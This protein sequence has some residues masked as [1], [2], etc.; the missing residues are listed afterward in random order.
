MG[1]TVN[2]NPKGFELFMQILPSIKAI[3][4]IGF[5]PLPEEIQ[6]FDEEVYA[7]YELKTGNT[8]RPLYTIVPSDDEME[9]DNVTGVMLPEDLPKIYK[10]IDFFTKYASTHNIPLSDRQR[11]FNHA[12]ERAPSMLRE[13]TKFASPKNEQPSDNIFD[14][15]MEFLADGLDKSDIFTVNVKDESGESFSKSFIP[16]YAKNVESAVMTY[17]EFKQYAINAI[18]QIF[19]DKDHKVEASISLRSTEEQ[20]EAIHVVMEKGGG[21]WLNGFLVE[22]FY[23]EY[24]LGKPLGELV[25]DMVKS[26]EDNDEWIDKVNINDLNEFEKSKD[27]L[28]VRLL[29]YEKN[30]KALDGYIYKVID[31]MALVVYMLAANNES[32]ITSYKISTDILK[33]WNLSEEYVLNWT[34]ENTA[35]LFKPYII[36]IEMMNFKKSEAHTIPGEE[37]FFMD[38]N[39]KLIKSTNG[40]YSLFQEDG[41]NDATIVFYKGAMQRLAN[42]LG[43]DL[44]IILPES[45]YAVVHLKSKFPAKQL[46]KIFR[47]IKSDQARAKHDILSDKIYLYTRNNDNLS[48]FWD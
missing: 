41:L 4:D 3:F 21:K 30:K 36:P 22:P 29:N 26:I 45:D 28:F 44:Y 7:L 6:E 16:A 24:T 10:G 38:Y 39:F 17:E 43:D 34:T 40:V 19:S 33:Q 2:L 14:E 5:I 18:S 9:Q 8:E 11:V 32:G 48:V 1:V 35:K 46:K 23:E 20:H 12:V 37:R 13:H 25:L 27:S 31:D 15:L 42:I 47:R